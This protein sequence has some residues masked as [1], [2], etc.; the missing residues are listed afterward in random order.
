MEINVFAW[1]S[2]LLDTFD[3]WVPNI[4]QLYR[5]ICYTCKTS[6]NTI[7]TWSRRT[8]VCAPVWMAAA[9]WMPNA[10][11]AGALRL[12]GKMSCIRIYNII[13]IINMIINLLLILLLFYDF[14]I[15]IILF[16]YV[17]IY[18]CTYYIL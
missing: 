15:I 1:I 14:I 6:I 11:R 4:P 10:A 8:G 3:L 17:Y 13:I 16:T 18:I 2:D 9:G 7:I 12:E 5:A